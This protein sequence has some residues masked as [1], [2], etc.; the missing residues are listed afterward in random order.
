MRLKPS[1]WRTEHCL[2]SFVDE[3]TRGDLAAYT[4]EVD[5]TPTTVL[6]ARTPTN[7]WAVRE[8]AGYKN[9]APTPEACAAIDAWLA[10]RGL[11]APASIATRAARR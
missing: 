7:T 3:I 9:A 11:Q 5:G 4:V 1:R 6:L 10:S 2:F 8:H